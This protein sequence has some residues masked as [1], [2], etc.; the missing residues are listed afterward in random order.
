[1]DAPKVQLC[2]F[3]PLLSRTKNEWNS[4]TLRLLSV[5]ISF[6]HG[7]T[8]DGYSTSMRHSSI[9]CDQDIFRITCTRYSSK[10]L[11]SSTSNTSSVIHSS[12]KSHNI[13]SISEHCILCVQAIFI[14]FIPTP[15]ASMKL[16]KTSTC[17]FWKH[18]RYGH[19]YDTYRY[20]TTPRGTLASYLYIMFTTIPSQVYVIAARTRCTT[21]VYGS[22]I[23]IKLFYIHT[24]HSDIDLEHIPSI[25]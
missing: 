6:T 4:H 16:I 21:Q 11:S 3:A 1:M 25:E 9:K 14:K 7:F 13:I 19:S 10:H 17:Q 24:P 15:L 20:S 12:G 18:G 8:S 22:G 23:R 5:W 2:Q